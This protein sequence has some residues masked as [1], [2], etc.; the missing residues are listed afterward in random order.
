[1]I[2]AVA[3]DGFGWHCSLHQG[4]MGH[5]KREVGVCMHARPS[6]PQR[7]RV[8]DGGCAPQNC[9]LTETTASGAVLYSFHNGGRG[10]PPCHAQIRNDGTLAI[11]DSLGVLWSVT[12]GSAGSPGTSSPARPVA[13]SNQ[14]TAGQALSDVRPL[15]LPLRTEPIPLG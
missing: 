3:L 2:L 14:I 10:T 9:D 15:P 13:G 4:S 8:P 12:G 11:F 1:M 7:L 6:R 5:Y